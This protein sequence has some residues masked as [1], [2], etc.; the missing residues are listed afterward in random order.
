MSG[1]YERNAGMHVIPPG[2]T[3]NK[4]AFK[5]DRNKAADFLEYARAGIGA[6]VNNKIAERALEAEKPFL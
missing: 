4:S 2:Q 6:A 5:F 3:N 1:N